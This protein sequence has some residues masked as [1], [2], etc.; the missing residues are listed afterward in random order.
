MS[1]IYRRVY[2]EIE[3]DNVVYNLNNINKLTKADTKIICVIKTDGY[4]HGA[5]PLAMEME[6]LPY[7]HGYAVATAEEALQLKNN[8]IRKPIIIIGY[9]FPYSYDEMI[10][11]DVRITVF[12]EDTLRLLDET[13]RKLGLMCNVH[14]KV[15]TG[16]SRIGVMPNEEGMNLVKT[17]LSLKN[18]RVEGVFTHFARADETDLQYAVKQ[19][20]T[21]HEFVDRCEKELDFKFDIVHCSNSAGIIAMPEANDVCVRAGVIMYGM[22]PSNDVDKSKLDIKP[23]LSL[24]SRIVYVKTVG[25]NT[26]ISYGGTF[27][28]SKDTVIATV[29]IGYGDGYPRLLSNVGE[30]LIRG[31]R[32]KILGRVCMDQMMVDVTDIEGVTEEDVV[33]LIGRDGDE[34]ITIEDLA[35][36]SGMLNYE[37]ACVIGKRVPRMY[38]KGGKLVFTKDYFDDVPL[39]CLADI[40]GV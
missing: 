19:M 35:D 38:Y 31:K 9:S 18:I 6:K 12:R 8:G 14:I 4:G 3:L 5:L 37:L 36:W 26:Q 24:R 11:R 30:V 22:W 10:V 17:A 34:K 21:F 39:T 13:A 15:D 25:P 28:T 16:M 27:V 20:N 23:L 2:A 29:P 32:A 1:K 33:T 7:V 40:S